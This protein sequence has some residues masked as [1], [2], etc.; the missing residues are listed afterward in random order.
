M[1]FRS[2]S[3]GKDRN[4]DLLVRSTRDGYNNLS[5]SLSL[6]WSGLV[7]AGDVEGEMVLFCGDTVGPSL[8]R[9]PYDLG[10]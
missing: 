1:L 6:S 8:A 4:R 5:L 7:T 3:G 9:P 2:G 10:T